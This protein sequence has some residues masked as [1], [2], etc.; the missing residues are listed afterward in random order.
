MGPVGDDRATQ[1]IDEGLARPSQ[2]ALIQ[3]RDRQPDPSR[4]EF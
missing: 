3:F 2:L 4:G 1:A